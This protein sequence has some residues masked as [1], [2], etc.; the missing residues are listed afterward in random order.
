MQREIDSFPLQLAKETPE[1]TQFGFIDDILLTILTYI[2]YSSSS[3]RHVLLFAHVSK[4][5]RRVTLLLPHLEL[6]SSLFIDW[7]SP[8]DISIYKSLVSLKIS[9]R[10]EDAETD[11]KKGHVGKIHFNDILSTLKKTRTTCNIKTLYLDDNGYIRCQH[12]MYYFRG[13]E[14]LIVQSASKVPIKDMALLNGLKHIRFVTGSKHFIPFQTEFI[15][16]LDHVELIEDDFNLMTQCRSSRNY[17]RTGRYILHFQNDRYDS[18]V[19]GYLKNGVFVGFVEMIC[20]RHGVDLFRYKGEINERFQRHGKGIFTEI[21]KIKEHVRHYDGEFVNNQVVK[22]IL[23]G[24]ETRYEGEFLNSKYH[25][26]GVLHHIKRGWTVRGQF[27]EGKPNGKVVV[28]DTDGSTY[29][30]TMKDGARHGYGK[31][32][33]S[34]GTVTYTGEFVDHLHHGKGTLRI[35]D[36][37]VIDALWDK[38]QMRGEL[39]ITLLK[40]NTF[41]KGHINENKVNG[42]GTWVLCNKEEG[43]VAGI[44]LCDGVFKDNVFMSGYFL[45]SDRNTVVMGSFDENDEFKGS[46]FKKVANDDDDDDDDDDNTMT[47]INLSKERHQYTTLSIETTIGKY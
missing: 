37:I 38:S 47:N 18:R 6:T 5:W 2:A 44:V 25:G 10:K 27:K 46:M 13:L 45:T 39:T 15:R 20:S 9:S 23:H 1:V 21:G 29:E 14:S 16:L 35:G 3:S 43:D 26:E 11:R 42:K 40:A 4:Q 41:F 32:T 12:L 8:F 28:N 19:E 31:F 34:L 24:N 36:E 33:N 7:H 22:G 30:G 17:G